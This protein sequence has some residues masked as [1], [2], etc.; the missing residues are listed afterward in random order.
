MSALAAHT[1]QKVLAMGPS[2]PLDEGSKSALLQT[3]LASFCPPPHLALT[4]PLPPPRPWPPPVRHLPWRSSTA[5]Y[6][7]QEPRRAN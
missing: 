3:L 5:G 2:V 6:G 1:E 4:L 7:S